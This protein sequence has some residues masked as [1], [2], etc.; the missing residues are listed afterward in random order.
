MTL[1]ITFAFVKRQRARRLQPV[2]HRHQKIHAQNAQQ[3]PA[4]RK[5]DDPA[6]GNACC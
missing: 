6:A 4:I 5:C 1:P 3:A 2:H